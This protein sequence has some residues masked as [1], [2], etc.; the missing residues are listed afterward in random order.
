MIELGVSVAGGDTSK[1]N[2]PGMVGG[3]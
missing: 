3:C 1:L 2:L